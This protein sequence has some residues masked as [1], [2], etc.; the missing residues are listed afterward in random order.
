MGANERKVINNVCV[1]CAWC[2][3]RAIFLLA[4]ISVF[5]VAGEHT[6]QSTDVRKGK[7]SIAYQQRS[8]HC[9]TEHGEHYTSGGATRTSTPHQL[10]FIAVRTSLRGAS[11]VHIR[12][13]HIRSYDFRICLSTCVCKAPANSPMSKGKSSRCRMC[14]FKMLHEGW[15]LDMNGIWW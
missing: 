12:F 8:N 13:F 6:D 11:G 9:H 15:N 7:V 10:H 14:G 3:I 1:I 4:L 2:S 5:S